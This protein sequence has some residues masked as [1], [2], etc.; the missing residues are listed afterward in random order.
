M[1]FSPSNPATSRLQ[2]VSE[3]DRIRLALSS[4]GEVVYDSVI[5]S[6]VIEWG[7]N[8][9]QE[10]QRNG[11][12]PFSSRDEFLSLLNPDGYRALAKAI[13]MSKRS[14]APYTVEYQVQMPN[15]AACWIEDRGSCITDENGNLAHVV[16][17]I[18]FI[19]EQKE[20]ESRL[21]YLAAY[22]DLT[23]HYNRSRLR[24]QLGE[25]LDLCWNQGLSAGFLVAGVDNL[26]LL[27]E[28]LGFDVADDVIIEIGSRIK[29]RLEP[30]DVLG[31]N[32]G[33][34][35]GVILRNCHS[36]EIARRVS[37]L[38]AAVR[39]S[40]IYTKAGPV[41]VTISI[42]YVVL[43]GQTRT[44]Q[45]AFAR[46]EEALGHAKAQGFDR[47]YCYEESE[48]HASHRRSKMKTADQI[49][50]AMN[51]DRFLLN[52]QPIVC[53][54]S[55]EPDHY[56]CLLRIHDADGALVPAGEFIPVAEELGL[57][58]MLDKKVL[59]MTVAKLKKH[60]DVSLALNVSG[61]TTTDVSWVQRLVDLVA[62]DRSLA[63]RLTVEITETV[64]LQ[65]ITE[66]SN[67]VAILR[68]IGCKVAIDDFG[69]G[70]TSYRNL[71]L[72]D[73]DAVKIDGTFVRNITDNDDNQFYVRTLNDLAHHFNL[74][75]VAECVETAQEAELLKRIGVDFLQGYYYGKPVS[76]VGASTP[77]ESED[78][79][80]LRSGMVK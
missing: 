26:A 36:D 37:N 65:D 47:A 10:F 72:L 50:S 16:G 48:E 42:G 34:K 63:S 80:T 24:A 76:E 21:A 5:S 71:K 56:E 6:G 18:R 74:K 77:V 3:L 75:T 33:N 32:A 53:A 9:E 29:D 20:R 78:A 49:V 67:F 59:D 35:F 31:R 61:L 60:P 27:N 79:Q 70:Y 17:V 25:V 38:K 69:A 11:L 39:D 58:R 30:Q 44:S 54:T 41:S 52:F 15:G 51:E 12:M 46:G 68:D 19:T 14:H 55:E 43:P 66:L 1:S 4:A 62:R 64:A 45:D 73:V 2:E 22:D 57:V 40:V 28:S 23:G 8:A 13:D 7:E